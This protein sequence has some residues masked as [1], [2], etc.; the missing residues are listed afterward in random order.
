MNPPPALNESHTVPKIVTSVTLAAMVALS[1]VACTAPAADTCEATPPGEHSSS[2]KVTGDFGKEPKVT[3]PTSF[4]ADET[5]RSVLISGDGAAALDGDMITAHYGAYNASTGEPV[6]LDADSTWAENEF[7][8]NDSMESFF[9]GLYNTLLCAQPG[10]RIVSAIPAVELFGDSGPQFGIGATD[11][12]IFIFD[13]S[14]VGPGPTEA[15]TP[16]PESGSESE[17][18]PTP[19][20]WVDNVPTVDLSADVPVVTL[21]NTAPSTELQLKVLEEG[22]GAIVENSQA[23]VTIDYQGTSWDTGEVFDQSYDRGEPSTFPVGGVI[24]G[25]AAALVGQKVGSTVLVTIP[26]EYAYGSDPS[27]HQL[28][29][30]TLVFLIKIH[31]V[32]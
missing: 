10:D 13:V 3:L 32:K 12:M 4:E 20:A 21:P 28:G 24:K 27:A 16:E 19:A 9:P 29:G 30:Q 25:F 17:P 15:P 8:V 23:T 18:L 5:E 7:G 31:D 22:T 14:K 2:I 6:Q 26:P 11:T 1:L